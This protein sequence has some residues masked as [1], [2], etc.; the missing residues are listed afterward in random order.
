MSWAETAAGALIAGSEWIPGT[1]CALSGR[2]SGERLSTA[3]A[4]GRQIHLVWPQQSPDPAPVRPR[5][6]PDTPR[7]CRGRPSLLGRTSRVRTFLGRYAAR[8]SASGAPE[9]HDTVADDIRHILRQLRSSR[10][11]PTSTRSTELPAI[12]RTSTRQAR[13]RAANRRNPRRSESVR[14]ERLT[15]HLWLSSCEWLGAHRAYTPDGR[16]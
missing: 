15:R 7:H 11:M 9:D 10:A 13:R 2:D 14:S 8:S 16:R 12:R 4:I 3:T 1:F 5:Q 6:L